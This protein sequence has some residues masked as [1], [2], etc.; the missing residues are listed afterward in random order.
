MARLYG[1]PTCRKCVSRFAARREWAWMID[2]FFGYFLPFPLLIIAFELLDIGEKYALVVIVPCYVWYLGWMVLKDGFR[3]CTPGKYVTRIRVIDIDTGE[4]LRFLASF[5][6]NLCVLIPFFAL[7]LMFKLRHGPRPGDGWA[8]SKV[9][10]LKYKD[11]RIF[12]P[13]EP[14]DEQLDGQVYEVVTDQANPYRS[15]SM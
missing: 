9:I 5:R 10:W 6:R 8:R 7:F 11:H 14:L 15:P 12:A 3:G 1:V 4:R 2:L 13:G